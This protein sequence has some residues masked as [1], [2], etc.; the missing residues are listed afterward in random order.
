MSLWLVALAWAGWAVAVAAAL[1]LRR[2]RALL[3]DAEHEL[4]GAATAIGLALERIGRTGGTADLAALLRLELDRMNGGIAGLAAATGSGVVSTGGELDAGRL[5][6][7]L[8]NVIAN[9]AEHGLGAV[10][11]RADRTAGTVRLEVSNRERPPGSA[12][13]TRR[14]G[15]GRGIAIAER[16]AA[17]LG[18]RLTVESADGVT[19]ALVELPASPPQDGEL[20][21]A[22]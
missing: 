12:P 21:R 20:H 19:R 7:V 18:G 4:R 8:A 15:R 22:A 13:A 14:A 9:A 6:Q 16:A 10:E 3:A 1:S 17:A 11:V 2:R 5:A